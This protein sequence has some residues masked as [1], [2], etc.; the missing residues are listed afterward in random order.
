MSIKCDNLCVL[1]LKKFTTRVIVY[2]HNL[3][4]NTDQD[5]FLFVVF[6]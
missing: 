3:N 6:N 5:T 2:G 4:L 1:N